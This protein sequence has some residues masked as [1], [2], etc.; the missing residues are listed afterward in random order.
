MHM[1]KAMTILH[2][3]P[4]Q[5]FRVEAKLLG[6]RFISLGGLAVHPKLIICCQCTI[7]PHGTVTQFRHPRIGT[8]CRYPRIVHGDIPPM[9]CV[10]AQLN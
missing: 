5:Y 4:F 1:V 8:L 10:H 6:V 2:V 9:R 7:F 3:I